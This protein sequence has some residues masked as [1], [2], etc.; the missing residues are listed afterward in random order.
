MRT[1][2]ERTAG[3]HGAGRSRAPRSSCRSSHA[4][5]WSRSLDDEDLAQLAEARRDG[6][7]HAVSSLLKKRRSVTSAATLPC[8]AKR[9]PVVGVDRR[10]PPTGGHPSTVPR[11]AR[12]FCRVAR[13]P[14]GSG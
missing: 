5:V 7:A 3:G 13:R 1:Q 14:P 4:R 9:N 6:N 12:R 2:A 11:Q 8:R 10:S